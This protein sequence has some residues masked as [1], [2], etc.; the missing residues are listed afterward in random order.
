M[1]VRRPLVALALILPLAGCAP[2]LK[3]IMRAPELSPVGAGISDH[4][5]D[6]SVHL[7]PLATRRRAAACPSISTSTSAWRMSATSSPSTSRS[8]TRPW[9]AIP[10]TA[11]RRQTAASASTG[12]SPPR[13]AVPARRNLRPSPTNTTSTRPRHR[14]ATATSTAPNRYNSPCPPSSRKFC[15]TAISS[16]RA[17]RRCGSISS[18]AN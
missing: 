5:P 14:K 2:Q 18:F 9:S 11:R 3:D 8:T 6:A 13:L 10:R 17:R 12:C 16:S 1:I 7:P 4:S 15:P